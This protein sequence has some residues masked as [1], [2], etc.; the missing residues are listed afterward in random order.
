MNESFLLAATTAAWLGILTS[1]S[2]CPLATNIAAISFIG[3]NVNNSRMV[4]LSGLFYM[5]GRMLVYLVVSVLI[6]TSLLAVTD[7]SFF[8]Q[9]DIN[10]ILGPVLIIAGIFLLG[11]IK[12][13]LPGFGFSSK[14][15]DRASRYGIWGAMMLGVTFALSFCP[16]SAA[17]FFGSLIPL[18]IKQNSNILIPS[19]FGIGTALPVIL[20]SFLIAFG[21]KS[22]GRMFD[23]L[24][25]FE[26]WARRVTGIIFIIVGAYYALIY[27]FRLDI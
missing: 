23:K 7:I 14:M 8:L 3:K 12:F 6:V 24:T 19:L 9:E 10:I 16:I 26:K 1:I 2:P 22:I 11:F 5:T 20:F 4:F 13:S 18:A 15:Q 27:L 21:V 25:L 17:L